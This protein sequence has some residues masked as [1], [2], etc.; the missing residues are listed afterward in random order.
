MVP[1]TRSSRA[2]KGVAQDADDM[3]TGTIDGF[4][5]T[6][7]DTHTRANKTKKVYRKASPEPEL[8]QLKFPARRKMVREKKNTP[9]TSTGNN[10]KQTRHSLRASLS[11]NKAKGRKNKEEDP[12]Q[13]TLTQ[14]GWVPST[15]PEGDDDMDPGFRTID[16][17]GLS[18]GGEWNGLDASAEPSTKSASAKK[19]ARKKVGGKEPARSRRGR[20]RRKTTGDLELER[21]EE[22][23]DGD[24]EA[25]SSSRYYTQTLTQMHSWRQSG[26]EDENDGGLAAM[27]VSD[28]DEG[29]GESFGINQSK[30]DLDTAERENVHGDT[31]QSKKRKR[32]APPPAHHD[33]TQLEE[34]QAAPQ[35]TGPSLIPATPSAQRLMRTEIPSSQPSPFTPNFDIEHR[36][37]SPLNHELQGVDRTPLKEKSSNV[38]APTPSASGRWMRNRDRSEVPDSWS[39]VNGGLGSSPAGEPS[40]VGREGSLSQSQKRIKR[41]PLKEIHFADVSLELGERDGGEAGLGRTDAATGDEPLQQSSRSADEV[42]SNSDEEFNIFDEDEVGG[43]GSPTPGGGRSGKIIEETHTPSR[44]PRPS[45]QGSAEADHQEVDNTDQ[46]IPADT[47]PLTSSKLVAQLARPDVPPAHIAERNLSPEP[48]SRT[49]ANAAVMIDSLDRGVPKPTVRKTATE[50]PSSH[51]ASH[52]RPTPEPHTEAIETGYVE[53]ETPMPSIRKTATQ[54]TFSHPTSN[55]RSTPEPPDEDEESEPET[56]THR[57]RRPSS[58]SLV[59]K[60]TPVSSPQKTS[61]AMPPVSQ[62]GWK[63]QAFES[64]RVPFEIIQQM[65]P[66]TD[67]SDVIVSIH[68]E[69]VKHIVDG[70]KTHEFRDFRLYSTVAR[71]WIYITKPVAELKYMATVGEYKLPGEIPLDDPGIGNAEFNEGKG[72]KYAYELRQV[73]QLNNPVSLERMKENGWVEQAP[74]K[75]EYVPPA[76]LGEL[77]SNL[78]CALFEEHDSKREGEGDASQSDVTISQELAQQLRSDIEGATQLMKGLHSSPRQQQLGED[79]GEDSDHVVVPSSQDAETEEHVAATPLRRVPSLQRQ[80][81]FAKPEAS[82]TRSQRSIVQID[83]SPP[84]ARHSQVQY[85][86][87]NIVKS[88]VRPSQATTASAASQSQKVLSQRLP[89]QNHSRSGHSQ[90]KGSGTLLSFPEDMMVVDDSPVRGRA[91]AGDKS[92]SHTQSSLGLGMLLRSSQDLG[93]A[94]I[95]GEQDSLMDDSRIRLPPAEVIWDSEGDVE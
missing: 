31:R 21:D 80:V 36:Y 9:T 38:D 52:R 33:P 91:A 14:I 27:V 68:P 19:T 22:D 89:S 6:Q 53:P 32:S 61:P 76:V 11:G 7:K 25:V 26:E 90:A 51:P 82:Q 42:I 79:H 18:D 47:A 35:S 30:T 56:P 75:F 54:L 41:T 78:R 67:R 1:T 59:E 10:K 46:S 58:S 77:M 28:S 57:R 70:T 15:F 63:S 13:S 3:N 34:E 2:S 23:H 44:R 83:D 64:Q 39:T 72:S 73:Y 43:S 66:Q 55:R 85:Q 8:E 45:G 87:Q 69:H 81:A 84:T 93:L 88:T 20:K 49:L 40:K 37:W 71:I 92:A 16:L 65:P 60:E 74:Q 94:G 50:P 24:E 86:T 62:V 29:L 48:A 4:P 5:N 95:G 17:T 12:K